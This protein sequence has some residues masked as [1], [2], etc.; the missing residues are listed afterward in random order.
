MLS[1]T[2]P[3]FTE[4]TGIVVCHCPH[5]YDLYGSVVTLSFKIWWSWPDLQN[6][7]QH[8]VYCS[9]TKSTDKERGHDRMQMC[10]C[11][12]EDCAHI[13]WLDDA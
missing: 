9:Q 7:H 2:Q 3:A 6:D 13:Y 4:P 8:Y 1:E 11:V 5:C 10:V 12:F